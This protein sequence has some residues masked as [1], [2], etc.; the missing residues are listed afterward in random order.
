MP[1]IQ[2]SAKMF[3]MKILR[4]IFLALFSINLFGSEIVMVHAF[5]GF[6]EEKFS[7]IVEGFNQQSHHHKV[8]LKQVNDYQV[9]YE[10]GLKAHKKGEGPHILQVY[11]VATLSM[12]LQDE[13]KG[14]SD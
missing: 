4:C 14:S 12:M 13:I 9:I 1:K 8:K 2:N 6:L 10:E 3:A 7:E 11:E 5:D